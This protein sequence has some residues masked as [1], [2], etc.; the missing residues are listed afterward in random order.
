[1]PWILLLLNRKPQPGLARSRFVPLA[2]LWTLLILAGS[3]EVIILAALLA[4]AQSFLKPGQWKK[5][6]AAADVLDH[7][8]NNLSEI[9]DSAY[10]APHFRQEKDGKQSIEGFEI[11]RIKKGGIAD[12]LSL[13]N[14]DIVLAV[15]GK[16]MDS[17]EKVMKLVSQVQNMPQAVMAV[18]R[19]T[20]K[21][22]IAFTRK[23]SGS[24]LGALRDAFGESSRLE[25]G[26]S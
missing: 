23:Y 14:G 10:A 9:L 19:G 4:A 24:N 6:L 16:T 5:R 21:I 15:N 2:V 12:R 22:T 26:G 20:Q 3:P 13:Q 7:Y 18:L 25:K 17:L 11:S 1:M 8:T